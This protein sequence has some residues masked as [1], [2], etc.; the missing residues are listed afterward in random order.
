MPAKCKTKPTQYQFESSPTSSLNHRSKSGVWN[1]KTY[2]HD[3]KFCNE[4]FVH[5]PIGEL[6]ICVLYAYHV[7]KDPNFAI[8]MIVEIYF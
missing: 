4:S 8:K 3:K 5:A 7:K 6:K 2:Q 1:D